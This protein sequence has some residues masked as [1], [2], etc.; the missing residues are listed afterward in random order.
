MRRWI[1][2]SALIAVLTAG[3]TEAASPATEPLRPFPPKPVAQNCAPN[4]GVEYPVYARTIDILQRSGEMQRASEAFGKMRLGVEA[5]LTERNPAALADARPVLDPLFSDKEV[6]KR[7]ACDFSQYAR[8][9]PIV[10]AWDTWVS[11]DTLRDIHVRMVAGA[12]AGDSKSV[13]IG[14]ARREL[15]RRL[16]VATGQTRFPAVRQATVARAQTIV[17]AALDP[18]SP[19]D[20]PP[21]IAPIVATPTVAAQDEQAAIEQWLAPRLADVSDRDL[22]RH[23]AFAESAAGRA[24]YQSLVVTYA[25]AMN[26]WYGQLG[27]DTKTRIAPKV[28]AMGPASVASGLAEVRRLLDIVGTLEVVPKARDLLT[29]LEIHDPKNAELQ[30]LRGRVEL[31]M[32]V[33]H[34]QFQPPYERGQIR[35]AASD[36]SAAYSQ[37]YLRP[38][39]YLMSAIALAPGNAEA[40]VYLGRL[41]FLQSKD[42]EA[43]KH[44]A[45]ARRLNPDVPSL[46]LFE[47][48]LA[49]ATGQFAKAER[50]YR[51][52]LAKPEDRVFNHY[53]AVKHLGYALNA[54]GRGREY[55][56]LAKAQLQAHP[57]VWDLRVDYVDDLLDCG[58]SAAE[59]MA[60]IEPIPKTWEAD[61]M[62]LLLTRVQL[63]KVVEAAP[64][65]RADI[66]KRWEATSFDTEA[67]GKALCRANTLSA[68]DTVMRARGMPDLEAHI[69]RAMLGCA[70]FDRRTE[71]VAAALPFMKDVNE[72]LNA[73]WQDTALCGAAARRDIKTLVLLLK[74]K[75]DPERNCTG[76]KTA[77]ERLAAM[78]ATGDADARAAIEEFERYLPRR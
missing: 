66:A 23:L 65:A 61:R 35:D 53:R 38:E 63:Q 2:F 41:S 68:V 49:Y 1:V 36:T 69:A 27:V 34:R 7:A 32:I 47:A 3:C 8:D 4:F 60:V 33:Q 24:F 43:A 10:D 12:A 78:A 52:V 59:A 26:E 20:R 46:A 31:E 71:A 72:P 57:E 62:H 45:Q 13:R 25:D 42:A 21:I 28:A 37:L 73:L 11:D 18:T 9:K 75:A 44:F 6:R 48:D 17:R 64:S 29:N 14:T 58:G 39:P 50:M 77:Q 76:G 40:H 67:V 51:S 70:V 16:W 15:L 19:V 74:A 5:V 22:Q 55:G 56:A 54:L 30:T